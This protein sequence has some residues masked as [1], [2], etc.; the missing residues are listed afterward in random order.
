MK[1]Y[2]KAVGSVDKLAPL[3]EAAREDGVL[4][5]VLSAALDSSGASLLHR[6]S[7]RGAVAVVSLL[8]KLGANPNARNKES[9]TPLHEAA[10][11]QHFEVMKVLVEDGG[12]DVNT[13]KANGWS[14]LH[15][16]SSSGD[17]RMASF[18]LR[19]GA[20]VDTRNRD[21]A[22]PLF[23]A[24]RA[25]HEGVVEELL[26]AGA[27]VSIRI[28]SNRSPL[29]V[30]VAGGHE[31]VVRQLLRVGADLATTDDLGTTLWHELAKQGDKDLVQVLLE[32]RL[33]VGRDSVR[34]QHPLH[35]AAI[36]G[37]AG[38]LAAL[39]ER[40]LGVVD[41]VDG[42]GASPLYYAAANGHEEAVYTL[43]GRGADPGFRGPGLPRTPLHCAVGWGHVGCSRLLLGAGADPMA[44]DRAGATPLE[45]VRGLEHMEDGRREALI[46]MLTEA[47]ETTSHERLPTTAKQTASIYR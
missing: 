44:R 3:L 7:E 25:G 14:S 35:T 46:A 28:Q 33:P 2:A 17:V 12:A 6:A 26:K 16:C 19:H 20:A 43:L 47:Q 13:H 21:G 22:T 23:L 40:G 11:H 30:A 42:D 9:K 10:N 1:P 15:F 34:K 5:T 31:G 45:V 32:R 36:F 41:E 38:F 37:Q 18:L 24:C 39:L 4:D 27:D 8:L 29:H